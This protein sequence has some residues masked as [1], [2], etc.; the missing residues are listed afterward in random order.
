MCAADAALNVSNR[1]WCPGRGSDWVRPADCYLAARARE[2]RPLRLV[3]RL[4]A[5]RERA[6]V[7]FTFGLR[8]RFT[9][10]AC[11]CFPSVEPS[12]FACRRARFQSLR[13]SDAC[14]RARLASRFASFRRLRARR[15][16]SFARRTRCWATSACNLALSMISAEPSFPSGESSAAGISLPVFFMTCLRSEAPVSHKPQVLATVPDR[17]HRRRTAARHGCRF[18][19]TLIQRRDTGR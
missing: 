18:R 12:F 16:S 8:R 4:L 17:S 11:F 5:R 9:V 2:P 14:L 19:D 3:L 1:P 6:G 15:N 7:D 10:I 13:V